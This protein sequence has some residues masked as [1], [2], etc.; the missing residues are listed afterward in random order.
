M[1]A[2]QNELNS[3]LGTVATAAAVGKHAYNQSQTQAQQKQANALS[4]A[5]LQMDVME[6]TYQ[7]VQQNDALIQEEA[8]AT[9]TAKGI[10]EKEA[11]LSKEFVN[12]HKDMKATGE[13]ITSVEGA[14]KDKLLTSIYGDSVTEFAKKTADISKER[15]MSNEALRQLA[16]KR[17]LQDFRNSNLTMIKN[18]VG[19]ENISTVNTPKDIEY[20]KNY[21]NEHGG[22]V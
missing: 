8:A 17:E 6:Q 2:I 22:R 13:S 12:L 16:N 21:I 10:T 9:E 5:K 20:T 19:M 7:N 4:K 15:E 1:G 18:L 11:A 14:D 3:A